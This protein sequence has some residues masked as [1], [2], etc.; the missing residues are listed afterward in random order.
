[1][2]TVPHAKGT[3]QFS[4]PPEMRVTQAVSK[5]FRSIED[6]RAAVAAAKVRASYDVL[7]VPHALLT[8]P[9]VQWK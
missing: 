8:L 1:M 3:I 6:E 2:Y 9:V 4:L 5:P 7:I